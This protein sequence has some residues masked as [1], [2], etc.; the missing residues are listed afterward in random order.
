VISFVLKVTMEESD[1]EETMM[2]V[3]EELMKNEQVK[4]LRL[5]EVKD[6]GEDYLVELYR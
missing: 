6:S 5:A 1:A 2:A 4:T 3:A